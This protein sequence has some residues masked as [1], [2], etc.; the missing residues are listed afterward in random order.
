MPT[1]EARQARRRTY[2]GVALIVGSFVLIVT[3]LQ[4]WL[5]Q[6][7]RE[8][9]RQDVKDRAEREAARVACIQTWGKAMVDTVETRT[10]ERYAVGTVDLENAEEKR[11]DALDDALLLL[12]ADTDA[13]PVDEQAIQDAARRYYQAVAYLREVRQQTRQTRADNPYPELEC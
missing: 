13:P 6:Q 9:N 10:G 12:R 7:E 2:V 5:Y 4:M 3:G 11:D 8:D 1:P